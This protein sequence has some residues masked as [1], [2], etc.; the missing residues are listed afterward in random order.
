MK[1]HWYLAGISLVSPTGETVVRQSRNLCPKL[2]NLRIGPF[3]NP[4][5]HT[6]EIGH[7]NTQKACF[8]HKN[9]LK[10]FEKYR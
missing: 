9:N 8:S 6:H 10:N 4:A 1:L 5:E 2:K 3:K 7:E